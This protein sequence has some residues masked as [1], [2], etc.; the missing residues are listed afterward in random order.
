M[1]SHENYLWGLV[2]YGLGFLLLL[3]LIF[4]IAKVVMPWRV[5]RNL[6]LIFLF[7]LLLTPVR[8]YTDM[9]FLA[10]AWMVTALEIIK[11][12][13]PE[14]AARALTPL[15]VTYVALSLSYI[16]WVVFW[17]VRRRN[18]AKA[19]AARQNAYRQ[20]EELAGVAVENGK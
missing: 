10:P 3:P 5:P 9:S 13:T 7:T 19:L 8:A 11:P 6:I 2:A 16:G 18:A 14:G 12:T 15:A 1:Y 17:A 20:W 4:T